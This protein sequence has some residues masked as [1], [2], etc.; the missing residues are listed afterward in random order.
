MIE[1]Q[2]VEYYLLDDPPGFMLLRSDGTTLQALVLDTADIAAQ[3][4]F[5]TRHGAPANIDFDPRRS[6]YDAYLR[7]LDD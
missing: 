5:V 4:A 7:S 3:L 6:S 1:E 2:L